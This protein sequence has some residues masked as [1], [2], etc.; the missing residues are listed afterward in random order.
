MA[1]PPT[2]IPS[3]KPVGKLRKDGDV[4]LKP[5]DWIDDVK[6]VKKVDDPSINEYAT[7]PPT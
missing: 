1:T 4:I 3:Q 5:K 2:A 6:V 7:P